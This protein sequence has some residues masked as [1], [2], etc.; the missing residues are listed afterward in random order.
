MELLELMR[1]LAPGLSTVSDEDANRALA[2][3]AS[4]RPQCLPQAKA[5][6]AQAWYAAWILSRR[7]ASAPPAAD[8]YEA[9]NIERLRAAGVKSEKEGDLQRTYSTASE[10][11][12]YQTDP[13]GYLMQYQR[14]AD[15]CKVGAITVGHIR[16]G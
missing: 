12:S 7:L 5:D 11:I 9:Q 1:F 3:A 15:L 2:L 4:Y 8:D 14:L 6:E 10:M 16:H 13:D